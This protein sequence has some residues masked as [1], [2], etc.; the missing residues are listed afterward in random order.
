MEDKRLKLKLYSVYFLAYSAYGCYA[1]FFIV[2]F[3]SRGLNFIQTGIAF[4]VM[5]L[6]GV[7]CQPA[8]GY[9]TDKYLN[10]KVTLIIIM[11]A[12]A[13]SIL[14]LAFAHSFWAILAGIITVSVFITSIFSLLDAFCYDISTPFNGIHFSR[15]RLAGSLGYALA[16]L[17]MGILLK[18]TSI[19]IS[20]F[21]CCLIE[22][23]CALFIIS[24]KYEKKAAMQRISFRDVA[25]LFKNFSFILFILSVILIN[26]VIGAN[27]SYIGE[28]IELTGGDV[29]NLGLLWFVVGICELP[30]LYLGNRI[31]GRFKDTSLYCIAMAFYTIRYFLISICTS[32][33][34]VITIQMMQSI[35][36]TFYVLSALNFLNRI[37]PDKMKATGITLYA[38]LGGGLGGFLGNLGG[39]VILETLNIRWLYR[40]L[41]FT[42]LL[43][44]ATGLFINK[45]AKKA[46]NPTAKN[47]IRQAIRH[48]I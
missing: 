26:I 38:A 47:R 10:K 21:L 8:W 17:L 32:W 40:I 2:Y 13:L 5:P 44:L 16:V 24:I 14:L 48:N 20:Y 12:S 18:Y 37:V 42:C 29:S 41:S 3:K 31:L 35:T 7:V 46:S 30:V 6:V 23:I 19:N 4:A 25:D 1:P 43:S 28:L 45:E 36:Y 11:V 9:I 27:S 15:A 33:S 22:A 34:M 39:G